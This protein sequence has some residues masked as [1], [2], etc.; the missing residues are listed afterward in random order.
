MA[1]GL[2]APVKTADHV[3]LQSALRADLKG[4]NLVGRHEA[5]G[6][7]GALTSAFD[8]NAHGL[9]CCWLAPGHD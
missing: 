8:G 1:D 6:A 2:L 9:T 5:R 3:A 4:S 7:A